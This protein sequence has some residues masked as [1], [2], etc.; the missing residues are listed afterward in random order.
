MTSAMT[1][2]PARNLLI[3]TLR[4]FALIGV[5]MVHMFEQYEIYWAAPQQ[6]LT[7]VIF[8]AFFM[9]KA[10]SLLTLCFGLSFFLL[11]DKADRRGVDFGNRFAWRM[12]VLALI[13]LVH[14]LVY[15]GDILMVLAPL[16]LVLIPYH[17]ASNQMILGVAAV[18][19][20]QPGLLYQIGGALAGE[21]W[22]NQPPHHYG[23]TGPAFYR[24]APLDQ[25]LVWNVW[26]G[27]SFKW[28]FFIETGRLF[29]ILAL[30]LV[31]L[32]LGRAGFFDNP[33]RFKAERRAA[34]TALAAF[35][36]A[37]HLGAAP[38]QA[39]A[40][41]AATAPMAR[42]LIGTLLGGW[43]DVSLMGVYVLLIVEAYQG[44]GR[45]LLDRLAPMGRMTLTFYVLQ[46]LIWVPVFYGFGLG[47]W[48]WLPQST[49]LW[50]GVGFLVVQGVAATLWFKRFHYGPL[51]WV[52]RAGTYRT[53]KVP[54]VR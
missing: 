53:V 14:S 50:L 4:A 7:H 51:E 25:L 44:V 31:G 52:W 43:F 16:G 28:W 27:Q 39:L 49:A 26:Q 3:D 21:V 1:A 15:R 47:A 23:D 33:D 11:M 10:F 42:K 32:R 8:T 19:L 48:K 12:A 22:A 35:A 36:I 9:G 46:S 45:K 41:D 38:L 18:L 54:F 5:Y 6:N 30:F 37:C 2:A 29:Q 13:G 20:A 24:T 34:L 17:R 40:P